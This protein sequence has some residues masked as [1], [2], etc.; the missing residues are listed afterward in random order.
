MISD[1]ELWAAMK[2]HIKNNVP[3][4]D[5]SAYTQ[6]IFPQLFS[7]E[8]LTPLWKTIY[9]FRD[10]MERNV[11]DTL[12]KT[13]IEKLGDMN[14]HKMRVAVAK[15]LIRRCELEL[16]EVFIVPRSNKFYSLIPENVFTVYID[17]RD[18]KIDKLLPQKDYKEMYNEV[19]FYVFCRKDKKEDVT[20][21]F[22]EII[23]KPLNFN[24]DNISESTIWEL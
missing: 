12:R 18:T 23:S 8:F 7:R 10:F 24:L 1:S 4:E 3:I 19:A 21:E 9:Q 5:L 14:D 6:R 16:G 22:I 2:S 11:E 15:E 20:R 17:H 13:A